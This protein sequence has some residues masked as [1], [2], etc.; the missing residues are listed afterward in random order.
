MNRQKGKEKMDAKKRNIII[1]A[2]AGAVILVLAVIACFGIFRGFDAQHYVDV[3][4]D[5]NLKGDVKSAVQTTKGLTEE[6]AKEQ[7][8]ST[9]E[10]FV[11]N[12]VASGLTLSEEEQ[13]QCVEISKKIFSD[14]KYEVQEAEKVSDDEYK[15]PVKYQVSDVMV[16][17]QALA[18]DEKAKVEEKVQKGEFRG[19]G[20]ELEAQ[21]Q[22]EFAK[23]LPT[24]L[25]TA[26]E[27]MEFGKEETMVLKVTK[28][29]NGLYV[30]DGT[31]TSQFIA[32]IMGLTVNQD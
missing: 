5:Q 30:L 21:M 11:A 13:K 6:Q 10:S 28:N 22:A 32:K 29:E 7:Y 31:Q 9:V 27:T 1:G 3:V 16:K 24:M 20:E 2:T 18:Q 25:Q 12:I 23:N 26:H 15:V 8:E 4:L 14:M 19:S 17:L